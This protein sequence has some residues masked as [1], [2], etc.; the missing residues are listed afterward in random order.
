VRNA[1]AVLKNGDAGMIAAVESGEI[2]LREAAETVRRDETA[3]IK[4]KRA[5]PYRQVH[6]PFNDFQTCLR[7]FYGTSYYRSGG[8][9]SLDIKSRRAL[10]DELENVIAALAVG[11]L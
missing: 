7:R 4:P 1:K 8:L 11:D 3:P 2:G 10:R 9:A 6:A 5:R